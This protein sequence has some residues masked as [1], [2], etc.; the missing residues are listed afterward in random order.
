MTRKKTPTLHD[1]IKAEVAAQMP[2]IET[3]IAVAM[4]N[5]TELK[6]QA[7]RDL[8]R[9]VSDLAK[10]LASTNV[11]VRIENCNISGAKQA[12]TWDMR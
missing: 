2:Q 8:S 4:P 1:K 6:M 5:T 11:N 12:I 3:G 10:A 7:I 9:A